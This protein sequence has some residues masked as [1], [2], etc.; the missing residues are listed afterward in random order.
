MTGSLVE[1]LEHCPVLLFQSADP[2]H[3]NGLELALGFLLVSRQ[4]LVVHG[5]KANGGIV[6]NTHHQNAAALGTTM[7]IMFVG[8]GN[9][10]LRDV[11]WRMRRR[12]RVL[13][14]GLTVTTDIV[15]A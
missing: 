7:F 3:I 15:D 13:K 5:L 12:L 11:V 9:V 1:L 14:H 6:S 4:L 2:V 8:E 10:N